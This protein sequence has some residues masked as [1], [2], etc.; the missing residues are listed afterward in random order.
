MNDRVHRFLQRNEARI[1][2][3]LDALG[4][5]HRHWTRPV[6]YER[7]AELLRALRPADLDALEI[8]AGKFF[9]TLGFRSYT[10]AN[11]PAF[12]ICKDVMDRQFDVV[13]A[14]QVWEHLLWPYRATRNVHA[15][16]KPGGHFLVTTPFLIRVHAIPHDCTRWTETGM[17]HFL[18]ECGFPED[19]IV[20]GSWGNRACVKANFTKW[21]R[22]G[23]FG[24]L[25]NEPDFPVVVW[26]LARKAG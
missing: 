8:S 23:W 18:A 4:Y 7:C 11:Y 5:D 21:A 17:R 3:G 2:S 13:I 9:Q 10:E 16:L 1:K 14:D 6:M 24:S 20:T 22:R 25:R 19:G 15:M 12:D 26:A